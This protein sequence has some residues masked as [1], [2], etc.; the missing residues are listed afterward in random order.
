M[1]IL[2]FGEILWDVFPDEKKIGGAPFNFAAHCAK[3]GAESFL[4][5]AVGNDVN[6][7]DAIEEAKKSG[8]DTRYIGVNTKYPTGVCNVFL[9][10][11]K[12]FYRL[13]ENTAFDHIQCG[14]IPQRFDGLY[15]GTL[16][17]R[18]PETR[19]SFEKILE[20][21]KFG[22]VFFDINLRSDYYTSELIGRLL[23]STTVLKMSDEEMPFFKSADVINT[24][25]ALSKK[26]GNLKYICITLGKNGAAVFDCRNKRILFSDTPKSKPISTVGAGDS[27]SA[28]FFTGLLSGL[29]LEECL[30]RGVK[31]SD[32]VV[33]KIGAVPDYNPNDLF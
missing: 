17:M 5:S 33:T 6:G 22:E 31:L 7:S 20:T 16:A 29:P 32:Y 13:A 12:P 3:L 25:L 28:A 4:V 8:V 26:H 9:K 10:D 30:E 15:M 24:V 1:K 2:S 19:R 27:F 21:A 18:S 11:G 23:K 14:Y